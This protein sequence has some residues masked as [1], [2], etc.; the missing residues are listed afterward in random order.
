MGL[1]VRRAMNALEGAAP[2]LQVE[3]HL[4]AKGVVG[5]DLQGRAGEGGIGAGA[6]QA[7]VNFDLSTASFRAYCS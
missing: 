1:Q 6:A 4:P 3:Q 5:P 2:A 7:R